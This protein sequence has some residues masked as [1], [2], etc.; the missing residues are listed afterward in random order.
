MSNKKLQIMEQH[1]YKLFMP[2]FIYNKIFISN[3]KIKRTI[4][5]VTKNRKSEFLK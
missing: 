4:N 1:V 3:D 5:N 2:I